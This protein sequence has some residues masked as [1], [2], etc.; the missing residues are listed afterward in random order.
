MNSEDK[1]LLLSYLTPS[2]LLTG[3]D[4]N[5]R[6]E[7]HVPKSQAELIYEH[8][9]ALIDD[10]QKSLTGDEEIGCSAVSFAG[11][12][13][14]YIDD[15][16]FRSPNLVTFHC[17]D[18]DGN[19]SMLIQSVSQINVLLRKLPK[20]HETAHRIMGFA[21]SATQDQEKGQDAPSSQTDARL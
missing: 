20:K 16:G 4:A 13:I 7:L 3:R 18:A 8:L 12:E 2:L 1:E 15:L 10:F 11:S 5:A 21:R 17:S 14:L 19:T 6:S 9:K